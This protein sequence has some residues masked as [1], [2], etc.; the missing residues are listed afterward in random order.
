AFSPLLLELWREVCRHIEIGESVARLAPI[1]ADH[2]PADFLIVRH[3]DIAHSRLETVA[4]GIC[5]PG[6]VALSPRSELSP[7]DLDRLLIW[8]R[9]SRN[10]RL[11]ASKV[12]SQL[13]GSLPAGMQ[14]AVLAGPLN[15]EQAPLG[16][17][18]FGFHHR[19]G[20]S[21]KD[22]KLLRALLEPFTVAM[23]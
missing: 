17:L 21:A 8:C 7:Q 14:G 6:H 15:T 16:V 9:Q 19:G 3:F 20:F 1:L 13:P 10:W 11:D 4:T 5:R 22:E 12:M 23:E 2:L 18:I